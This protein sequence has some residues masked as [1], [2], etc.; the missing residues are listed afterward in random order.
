MTNNDQAAE[1]R[2]RINRLTGKRAKT[3]AIVSGKGGVGKSNISLNFAI[4]LT[5]HGKKVLIF[6]MDIGMGNIHVLTGQTAGRSIADF[7]EKDLSLEELIYRDQEGVSYI[8]GGSGLSRLIEW[9]NSHFSRWLEGI[10]A[11]QEQYDYLLF[12]MGA[13]A[14]KEALN[15]LMSVDD[16]IVVTTPEP[17]SIT[18]AYSMMK[19]IHFQ[20]GE[21]AFYLLC[22]RADSERE[23][24][25]AV[26]RLQQAIRKFLGKSSF[27]LGVLPESTAV[28]KAVSA[29]IPFLVAAPNAKVSRALQEAVKLYREGYGY[30]EERPETNSFIS[31]LRHFFVKGRH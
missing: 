17:T 16:I 13:G 19:Y 26:K 3:V 29:Q 21:S 31:K 14:T 20:G 7:F 1:L 10:E 25:E 11:L 5:R 24:Q 22:N 12:D 27:E 15:V 28:K 18:D 9:D 30:L 6:D 23:G 8:L 4:E 2:R